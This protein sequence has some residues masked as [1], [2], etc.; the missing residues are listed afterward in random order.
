MI[1]A[2]PDRR[3]TGNGGTSRVVPPIRNTEECPRLRASDN[4]L[5]ELQSGLQ[6]GERISPERHERADS[7]NLGVI[8]VRSE[9]VFQLVLCD[10]GTPV[11]K[12]VVQRAP[13][14]S[15]ERERKAYKVDDPCIGFVRLLPSMPVWHRGAG[16][17]FIV[18]MSRSRVDVLPRYGPREG[19]TARIDERRQRRLTALELVE[20]CGPLPR[21][22][23]RGMTG[24]MVRRERN[25]RCN[26]S[27]RLP[28]AT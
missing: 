26:A 24:G 19:L 15:C 14:A 6:R 1:T 27:R 23:Q 20:F 11:R 3:R 21:V 16:C 5:S 25:P 13:S 10:A 18:G 28:N 8:N 2:S 17:C 22:G 4:E 12:P 7:V 9:R